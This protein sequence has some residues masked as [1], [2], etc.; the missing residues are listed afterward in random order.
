MKPD[1]SRYNDSS[2]YI[3]GL[4]ATIKARHRLSQQATARRLGIG[5]TTLKDWMSGKAKHRYPDQF[6]LECLAGVDSDDP[7]SLK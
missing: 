2:E 5:C 7:V 3:R 6:A 1:A 4:V